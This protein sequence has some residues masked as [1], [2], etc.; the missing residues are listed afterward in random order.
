V[1]VH[2]SEWERFVTYTG[3]GR[4]RDRDTSEWIVS[5]LE[6]MQQAS[7][8][9]VIERIRKQGTDFLRAIER[10]PGGRRFRHTFVVAASVKW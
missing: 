10:V 3:V 6:G 2:Y 1:T 5:W 7:P 8:D 4:W 9:E